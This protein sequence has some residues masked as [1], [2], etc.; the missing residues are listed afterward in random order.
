VIGVERFHPGIA[1]EWDAFVRQSRNG[2]FLF[3]RAYMDYHAD[4]FQD[5]SFLVRDQAGEL[6]AVLP[7]NI[8][9]DEYVSHGGLTYGGVVFGA[10]M[11]A[12]RM[13]DLL[14]PLVDSVFALGVRRFVYKAVPHVYHRGAAEE[15][16]WALFRMGARLERRDVSSAIVRPHRGPVQERRLRG[17]KKAIASGLVV[18]ESL[19]WPGYWPVLEGN[20]AD[21]HE[22]RPVHSLEEITL[23]AS[24]FP[25]AIRLFTVLGDGAI[26]AGAV[27]YDSMRVAHAQYIASTTSGR[28]RGALDLLFST[29]VDRVYAEKP[30]FDFGRSMDPGNGDLD[31]GNCGFKESFGARTIVYDRFALE[32]TSSS[33][34]E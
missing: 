13:R 25:K 27:I 6:V 26:V 9:A 7:G 32:R 3:E 19:D 17:R 21:R 16:L 20:L 14:V 23:L 5:A 15:D 24:R 4:R 8:T 33:A 11:T 30:V 34:P 31:E 10:R 2:S 1:D 28:E 22:S 18:E 12:P 29:L